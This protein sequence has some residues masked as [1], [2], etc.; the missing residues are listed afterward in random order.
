MK[1]NLEKKYRNGTISPSDLQILRDNVANLSDETLSAELEKVWDEGEFN[2]SRVPGER[3]NLLYN[4]I[5]S[6]NN[7]N[8]F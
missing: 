6:E 1:T 8:E 7:R 3:I 5:R 4:K 2:E